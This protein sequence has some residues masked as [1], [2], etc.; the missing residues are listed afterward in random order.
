MA[1]Y[2][3]YL[4]SNILTED[5]VVCK[6]LFSF[7]TVLTQLLDYLSASKSRPQSQCQCSKGVSNILYTLCSSPLIASRMLYD[8]H[9]QQNRKKPGTIHATYLVS[10]TKQE[11]RVPTIEEPKKDGED[12]YMQS[13]PFMA[14][15]MPQA[16]QGTGETGVLS[17]TLVREE[18]L[19]GLPLFWN[20]THRSF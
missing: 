16:E 3:T 10:G 2:K 18:N 14:S 19:A 13:S 8:F 6:L 9:R 15:S 4:A 20:Y 11:D 5:K 7:S 17:I 12:S 1:D